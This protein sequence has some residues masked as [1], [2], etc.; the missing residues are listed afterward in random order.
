[1]IAST[2]LSEKPKAMEATARPNV[3]ASRMGTRPTLSVAIR[4]KE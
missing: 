1:M 3:V 4:V 2:L